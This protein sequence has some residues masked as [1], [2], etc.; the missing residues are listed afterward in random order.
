MNFGHRAVFHFLVSAEDR[1][2]Y[3]EVLKRTLIPNGQ[4]IIA[5]FALDD[6][7]CCMWA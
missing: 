2:H 7:T 6:P 4:V 3:V 1:Q 5:A